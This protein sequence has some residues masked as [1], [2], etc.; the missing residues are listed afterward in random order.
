MSLKCS[1]VGCSRFEL[2]QADQLAFYQ[3][4]NTGGWNLALGPEF[5]AGKSSLPNNIGLL[6]TGDP[7]F[8]YNVICANCQKKIGKVNTI[9]GF[10][11]PTVNFSA[12][13]VFLRSSVYGTISKQSSW[14]KSISIFPEIRKITAIIPQEKSPE[15]PDTVHFHGASDLQDMIQAGR[16]VALK[17]GLIPKRYQWRA[18]FFACLQN[19]LLCLPTGMGKTL[20]ANLLM[21]AYL[22]RNPEKG[23]VFI[24]P[25]VVLV[26]TF[27][28]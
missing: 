28:K 26:N 1:F 6:D 7:R 10:E 15:G 4:L 27:N 22:Q 19:C 16:A 24:V 13:K 23:Q 11:N 17:S 12:K 25:T 3:D 2:S 21:K 9:C 18:Y 14:G 20:I 8:P 5:V